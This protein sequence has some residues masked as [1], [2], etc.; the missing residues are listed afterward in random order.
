MNNLKFLLLFLVG[1]FLSSCEQ[2]TFEES[3]TKADLQLNS[4][5]SILNPNERS[6]TNPVEFENNLQWLSFTTS[7]LLKKDAGCR[8]LMLSKLD[9]NNTV[10]LDDLDNTNPTYSFKYHLRQRLIHY[11]NSPEPDEE[12]FKPPPPAT[13]GIT[14][15]TPE[16]IADMIVDYVFDENCV[17]FYFPNGITFGTGD[18]IITSTAHPMTTATSNNGII[19]S[20]N[21]QGVGLNTEATTVD[22]TYLLNNTLVIVGRPIKTAI[23]KSLTN[24]SYSEYPNIDFT[25]FLD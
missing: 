6:V 21:Y 7:Y 20:D 19:R 23:G 15:L 4:K 2:E 1:I 16:E 14:P 18:Y 3:T 24:C 8:M 5:A 17:E 11:F 10:Q 13:G 9:A 12:I 22:D 25:D